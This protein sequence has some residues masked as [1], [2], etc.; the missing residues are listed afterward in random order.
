MIN[1]TKTIFESEYALALAVIS[2]LS[3][4]HNTM[5][6]AG[7]GYQ[8]GRGTPMSREERAAKEGEETPHKRKQRIA[9]EKRAAA[10]A[11][12]QGGRALAP[13]Q[14]RPQRGL[15]PQGAS[16]TNYVHDEERP[17]RA[18]VPQ[19]APRTNFVHDEE[20]P[21]QRKTTGT[22]P[23]GGQSSSSNTSRQRSF[24][25]APPEV[26]AKYRKEFPGARP[27]RMLMKGTASPSML[28]RTPF[29]SALLRKQSKQGLAN[30]R[31]RGRMAASTEIVRGSR[32]NLAEIAVRNVMN[33][34]CA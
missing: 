12:L 17:R 30:F 32:M 18:L 8:G 26:M 23:M 22:A 9:R 20:R 25:K 2:S 29:G 33:A 10:L 6:E 34:L 5:Q 3:N 27:S 11:K 16:K 4:S 21:R 15:V 13:Y 14:D 19:S 24:G 7:R 31:N 28:G 1:R